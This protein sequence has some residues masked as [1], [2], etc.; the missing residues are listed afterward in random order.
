MADGDGSKIIFKGYI[1]T[2][3]ESLRIIVQ[4]ALEE[5]RA[6]KATRLETETGQWPDPESAAGE[7]QVETHEVLD[8][9]G[10]RR[11]GLPEAVKP[12]QVVTEFFML[13]RSVDV[14][15][16]LI[17]WRTPECRRSTWISRAA[18]SR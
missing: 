13:E 3:I 17:R 1:T 10:A 6:T 7:A 8:W 4:Q 5:Q 16:K 9:A 18:S 12:L 11:H 2:K 14:F 15:D